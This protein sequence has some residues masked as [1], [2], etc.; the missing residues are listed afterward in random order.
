MKYTKKVLSLVLSLSIIS[1]AS[2][3]ALANEKLGSDSVFSDSFVTINY[4]A[5]TYSN[6]VDGFIKRLYDY[7]FK[8]SCSTSDLEYWRNKLVSGQMNAA[9]VLRYFFSSKEFNL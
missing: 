3:P 9:N 5:T 8:R 6:N 7:V 4:A 2:I 1:S